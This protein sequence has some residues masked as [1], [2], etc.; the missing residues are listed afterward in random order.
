[1][2]WKLRIASIC[3]LSFAGCRSANTVRDPEYARVSYAALQVRCDP[4]AVQRAVSPVNQEFSGPQ[5]VEVFIHHAISQNARVQAARKRVDAAAMRVPQAASLKD[6]MLDVTGWPFFPNVPQTASGRMTVDMMVSQEIPWRGKLNKQAA[7]AEAE[8]NAARAQLAAAELKVVEEVKLAYFDL[9]YVQRTIKVIKEDRKI[10]SDLIKVSEAMYVTGKANQQGVLRLQAELF[11]IDV[12]FKMG[13]AE[14]TTSRAIAPSADGIDNVAV[15]LG[16]NLP[17][18]RNRLRAAVLRCSTK[19]SMSGVSGVTCGWSSA[20][21]KEQARHPFD[22]PLAIEQ[23]SSADDDF[24]SF[25]QTL[26]DGEIAGLAAIVI[27]SNSARTD[28][29]I[30]QFES[31]VGPLSVRDFAAARVQYG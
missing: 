6:P 1:M 31:S 29:Q 14:M 24:V 22:L 20:L 15:G 11:N 28:S 18:Y 21:W 19:T 30:D 23:E 13:W 17:I 27:K 5:P 26:R 2:V 25:G 10:L 7:A 9:Y 8:V 16:M 4:I 12:T 3:L